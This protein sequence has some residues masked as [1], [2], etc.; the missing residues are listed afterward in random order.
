LLEREDGSDLKPRLTDLVEYLVVIGP[1][2][3][4]VALLLDL[5]PPDIDRNGID[6][7]GLGLGEQLR[8]RLH[9]R[10][11]GDVQRRHHGGGLQRAG[12]AEGG[13]HR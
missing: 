9:L 12:G 13:S 1:V 4:L 2:E 5:A 8:E 11:V 6:P 10:I 3:L 7:G